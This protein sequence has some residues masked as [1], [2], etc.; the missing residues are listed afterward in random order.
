MQA[1]GLVSE[2]VADAVNARTGQPVPR[3]LAMNAGS[4][5]D[6]PAARRLATADAAR[7]ATITDSPAAVLWDPQQHRLLY[8]TRSSD[9]DTMVVAEVAIGN[10]KEAEMLEAL[11]S[12]YRQD[13][14]T[15]QRQIAHGDYQIIQGTI[16]QAE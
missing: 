5:M 1:L 10:G 6:A 16:N 8:V 15:L 14:A 7:L 11:T 3:L 2:S 9:A 4:L 13:V 12:A